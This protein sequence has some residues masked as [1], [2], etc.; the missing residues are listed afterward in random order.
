VDVADFGIR[1]FDL[2]NTLMEGTH[3]NVV[4]VDALP[5]GGQ[6]GTL[7]VLEPRA[8]AG[9]LSVE[10]HSLDPAT[11]LRM[12]RALG[13]CPPRVLVVGCE[14]ASVDFELG[15]LSPPVAAAVD[16]AVQMVESLISDLSTGNHA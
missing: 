10:P 8:E 9:D 11:V 5:Q 4:L 3:A 14:P 6:P 2:A 12:I 15:G 1:G 7:Y 16:D 13:G